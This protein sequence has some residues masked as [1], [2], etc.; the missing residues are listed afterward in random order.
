MRG[1]DQGTLGIHAV[2][3]KWLKLLSV[4]LL[5]G[6]LQQ[7]KKQVKLV[8]SNWPRIWSLIHLPNGKDL[9]S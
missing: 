8:I 2:A 4:Y 5:G 1:A 7:I 9:L 3:P 6:E